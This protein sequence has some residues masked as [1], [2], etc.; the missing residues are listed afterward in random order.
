[1]DQVYA[2]NVLLFRRER[3]DL[4]HLQ[5]VKILHLHR[6]LPQAHLARPAKQVHPPHINQLKPLDR[7]I[8][9]RTIERISFELIS[10]PVLAKPQHQQGLEEKKTLLRN[11]SNSLAA[12]TPVF[13]HA[14]NDLFLE[15]NH[16]V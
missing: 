15:N 8:E 7:S 5:I 14:I 2:M 4:I 10:I 11:L 16:P 12:T 9:I 6:I 3:M 1:M 13:D